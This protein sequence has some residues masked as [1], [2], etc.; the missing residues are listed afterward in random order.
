MNMQDWLRHEWRRTKLPFYLA[1]EACEVRN[2]ATRK[3]LTACHLW[4]YPPVDAFMKLAHYANNHGDVAGRP[5][6]SLDGKTP[7]SSKHWENMRAKFYCDVGV[8]NVWHEPQV[9][10]DER[11]QNT[12]GCAH[13]NQ[14]PLRLLELVVRASSDVGDMVWEP[15]GGL[16]SVA[17][18]SY[19]L[20]RRCHSAELYAEYFKAA[21]SRFK[22]AEYNQYGA[23]PDSHTHWAAILGTL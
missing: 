17:I 13:M 5:Y 21:K 4:Y 10:G 2:A 7:I 6:F 18:A 15:F 23:T 9:R 8:T 19:K 1:N 20:A 11:L 22:H 14:K 12:N 16:C 3:Y